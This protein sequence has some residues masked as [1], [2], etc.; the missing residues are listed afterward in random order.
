MKWKKKKKKKMFRRDKISLKLSYF[1]Q[2]D[3]EY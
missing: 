2:L 1:Y 3:V